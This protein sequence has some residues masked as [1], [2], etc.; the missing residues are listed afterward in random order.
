MLVF[1][2]KIV[3]HGRRQGNTAQALAQWQHL[4]ASSVAL[5]VRHW[6]MHITLYQCSAMANE[7]ANNLPAFFVVINSGVTHNHS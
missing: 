2:V 3:G 1:P 4:V 7:K 5:D 6:V